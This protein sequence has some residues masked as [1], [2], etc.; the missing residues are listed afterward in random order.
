MHKEEEALVDVHKKK[1]RAVVRRPRSMTTHDYVGGTPS[2]ALNMKDQDRVLRS[3]VQ[4]SG[5]TTWRNPP[6]RTKQHALRGLPTV[7]NLEFLS[8]AMPG[9]VE[10]AS[11]VVEAMGGIGALSWAFTHRDSRLYL[12]LHPDAAEAAPEEPV[13][14]NPRQRVMPNP[15]AARRVIGTR[16]ETAANRL[17]LR[18]TDIIAPKVRVL[19][20]HVYF[21]G[22]DTSLCVLCLSLQVVEDP[23]R[24]EGEPATVQRKVLCV[25]PLPC[26]APALV[27]T[28]RILLSPSPGA[29]SCWEWRPC[30]T[31]STSRP[32]LCSRRWC[33][34][35]RWRV[36]WAWASRRPTPMRWSATTR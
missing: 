30:T 22:T 5:A 11:N 8:V 36:P 16:H 35:P 10:T 29:R 14:D 27:L 13:R 3:T 7:P 25:S 4:R 31:R 17:V 33:A 21:F 23:T 12:D 19:S 28:V 20:C 34:S 2:S 9:H 24:K 18:K 15:E 6:R 1:R 32:I 26:L